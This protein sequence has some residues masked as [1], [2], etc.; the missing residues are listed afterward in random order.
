MT[1]RERNK[2][3]GVVVFIIVAMSA[4]TVFAQGLIPR[5]SYPNCPEADP[6]ANW[7]DYFLAGTNQRLSILFDAMQGKPAP[8]WGS[9]GAGL[10]LRGYYYQK[11]TWRLYGHNVS[12]QVNYGAYPAD[13][14]WNQM[15]VWGH[16]FVFSSDT[17]EVYD[18]N[19]GLV[20]H[21]HC[22]QLC[23]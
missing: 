5:P 13:A 1:S 17:G 14:G 18:T 20:G 11:S 7:R 3:F 22:V 12:G 8:G 21:L 16:P 10:C 15:S 23:Q 4:D 2:L 6:K 19:I 9:L